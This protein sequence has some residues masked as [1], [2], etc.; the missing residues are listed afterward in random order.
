MSHHSKVF[1]IGKVTLHSKAGYIIEV[2]IDRL[3]S[4]PGK[5]A[6]ITPI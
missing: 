3:F 5:Q 1:R 4:A 2:K 6:S